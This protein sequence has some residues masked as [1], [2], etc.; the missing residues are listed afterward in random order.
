MTLSDQQIER[1]ARQIILPEVGGRGQARLLDATAAVAGS[2]GAARFARELL[3]R[4]GLQTDGDAPADVVVDCSGD[5]DGI[6]ARGRRAREAGRPL[7]VVLA[8][9]GTADVATLVGHPCVDCAPLATAAGEPD[10][11]LAMALGALAA[12]EALRVVLAPP[13]DGRVQ[14]LDLRTGGLTARALDGPRC[15]ACGASAS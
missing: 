13:P 9:E 10:A 1:F 15:A 2:G 12:G 3:A 4:A 6:V 8:G 5:R 14:T 11:P 7:V